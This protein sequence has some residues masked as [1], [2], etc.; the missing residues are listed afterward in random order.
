MEVLF[1]G[2]KSE[3][4]YP[5]VHASDG[6]SYRVQI[7]DERRDQ[8]IILSQFENSTVTLSGRTDCLRGHWR[9]TVRLEDLKVCQDDRSKLAPSVVTSVVSTANAAPVLPENSSE[10]GSH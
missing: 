3:G 10:D 9:I 6:V 8:G 7:S 1:K 2:S 4:V 5:V